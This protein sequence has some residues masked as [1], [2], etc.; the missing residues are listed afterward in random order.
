M[1]RT[2]DGVSTILRA[3]RRICRMVGLFGVGGLSSR[4]TPAFTAAVT[5][6]VAACHALE[7]LDDEP[8]VIDVTPPLGDE[9]VEL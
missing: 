6:L 2:V 1:A 5:A 7:L 3:A 4:T 8:T 9:D